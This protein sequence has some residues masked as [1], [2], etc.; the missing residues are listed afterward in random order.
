MTSPSGDTVTN[1]VYAPSVVEEGFGVVVEVA[2]V[3][4][5]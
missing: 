1:V 5:R 4:D 3:V 2:E